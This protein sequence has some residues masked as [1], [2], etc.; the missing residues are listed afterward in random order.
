MPDP[1]LG[2]AIRRFDGS[3]YVEIGPDV[4]EARA[5]QVALGW[6]SAAEIE[7]HKSKGSRAFRC[8]AREIET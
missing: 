4:T 2:Y 7:W 8:E 3:V 1:L 5:W 6:P